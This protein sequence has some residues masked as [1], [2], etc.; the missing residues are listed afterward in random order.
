MNQITYP[1]NSITHPETG[2]NTGRFLRS[3]SPA[4]KTLAVVVTAATLTVGSSLAAASHN[5]REFGVTS[6]SNS[7]SRQHIRQQHRHNDRRQQRHNN[8]RQ[9]Y[10][11]V[12]DVRPVYRQV[13]VRK[14]HRQCW[15]EYQ[16]NGTH[17][18][19]QHYDSNHGR[20][21]ERQNR[22]AS[23]LLGTIVGGAIG[24]RLGRYA[25]SEARIG[26]T[27]AGALIGTVIG[28]EAIASN[29]HVRDRFDR[30]SRNSRRH[31]R[32]PDHN[33][34]PSRRPVQRCETRTITTTE[35]RISG[36][37]VAYRYHGRV[38]HTNTDQHPG[39][40]IAIDVTVRPRN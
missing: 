32:N 8:R 2:N 38:Y 26:A 24:N 4:L 22:N 11:R 10:G 29:G 37:R 6:H 30:G 33:T 16:T 20:S 15:T 13:Q 31:Q 9:A 14:P 19:G 1:V 3:K 40:R 7:H 27:I 21:S 17:Y 34:R 35:D 5:D 36:Y 28:N 39:E 23:P 18:K 12:I 25:G